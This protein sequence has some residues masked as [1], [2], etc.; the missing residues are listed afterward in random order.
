MAGTTPFLATGP[1]ALAGL[2]DVSVIA[3]Q[4][5]NG[6][7]A[8]LRWFAPARCPHPAVLVGALLHLPLHLG[9]TV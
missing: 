1:A 6:F 5:E 2:T 7:V 8:P 3:L 4:I 9:G